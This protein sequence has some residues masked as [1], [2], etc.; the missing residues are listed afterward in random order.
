MCPWPT[1]LT[2]GA[3]GN[4]AMFQTRTQ[5]ALTLKIRVFTLKKIGQVDD[6][7]QTYSSLYLFSC[8]T[9]L[10]FPRP[11]FRRSSQQLL[12]SGTQPRKSLSLVP[13]WQVSPPHIPFTTSRCLF[14]YWKPQIIMVA[15][16]KETNSF[17]RQGWAALGHW[18]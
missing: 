8:E 15:G 18:S 4:F 12:L 3:K 16:S 1:L 13:V 6:R 5:A 9:C 7:R 11:A 17:G 10:I 14:E 2:S